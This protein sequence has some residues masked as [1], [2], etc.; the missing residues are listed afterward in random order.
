MFRFE[1]EANGLSLN[2][3]FAFSNAVSAVRVG[4]PHYLLQDGLYSFWAQVPAVV[5]LT[6][7]ANDP[8]AIPAAQVLA[9]LFYPG[10]LVGAGQL[11]QFQMDSTTTTDF[12]AGFITPTGIR[13]FRIGVGPAGNFFITRFRRGTT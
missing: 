5:F 10:A 4:S 2:R 1:D 12:G 3:A 13:V 11:L 9:P 8:P 6:D 7:A